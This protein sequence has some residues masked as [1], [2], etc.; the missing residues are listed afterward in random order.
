MSTTMI[1]DPDQ[2]SAARSLSSYETVTESSGRQFVIPHDDDKHLVCLT[3][4]GIRPAVL[5]DPIYFRPSPVELRDAIW[6]YG[7][8]SATDLDR[9]ET[10]PSGIPHRHFVTDTD[11]GA[12]LHMIAVVC[13]ADCAPPAFVTPANFEICAALSTLCKCR[14]K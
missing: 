10:C 11:R 7:R 9:L 3:F 12:Q 1:Y 2:E 4:T 14:M 5:D 8:L 6:Q 13:R